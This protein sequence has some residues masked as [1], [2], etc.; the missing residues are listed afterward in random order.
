MKSFSLSQP[1]LLIMVG[2]PGSGKSFFAEKFSKTF[3]TPLVSYDTIMELAGQD[4]MM[5]DRYASHL[6]VE[7]F[8]TK[9]AVIF[10]GP[11]SGRAQ[12]AELKKFALS[13]GYRPLFVWVQ[14]DEAT[15]RSRFVKL[16]KRMGRRAAEQ[17][18]AQLREFTPP[19][20]SE[21]PVVVISGKHT[22]ATQTKAVLKNLASTREA[23]RS[24]RPAARATASKPRRDINTR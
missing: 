14:T 22:Y 7:L 5:A 11:A 1:H 18:E 12:R 3:Q 24:I 9:H 21:H 8:K 20:D 15:A 23:P 4:G 16:N 10:D 6:L 13:A 2:I 19:S 17:F